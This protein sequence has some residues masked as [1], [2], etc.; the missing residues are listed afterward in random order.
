MGRLPLDALGVVQPLH[1]DLP[2]ASRVGFVQHHTGEDTDSDVAERHTS[3]ADRP[4]LLGGGE[5]R[6]VHRVPHHRHR[7]LLHHPDGGRLDH[8][9][10]WRHRQLQQ[11]HQH[12]RG[13]GRQRGGSRR[14][15][16]GRPRGQ[17]HQ[18]NGGKAVPK[19]GIPDNPF[20]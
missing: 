2:V 4:E 3:D 20:P 19:I 14:R 8:P 12:R 5:Q 6:G 9:S 7:G 18:G 13:F 11:E 10:R 15:K 16:R 17:A 1:T